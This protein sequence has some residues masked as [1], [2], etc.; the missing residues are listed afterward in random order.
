MQSP[1]EKASGRGSWQ[2]SLVNPR[3]GSQE[4]L[5]CAKGQEVTVGRGPE[6]HWQLGS[7]DLSRVHARFYW[8]GDALVVEDLDSK[9][10]TGVNG[11]RIPPSR[12]THLSDGDRV[13][14][15]SEFVDVALASRQGATTAYRPIA[16]I[17]LARLPAKQAAPEPVV[18]KAGPAPRTLE[19]VGPSDL[20]RLPSIKATP[21]AP[22]AN[23]HAN[24]QA[25]NL[26]LRHAGAAVPPPKLT[27]VDQDDA[28]TLCD[29]PT[30]PGRGAG[31]LARAPSLSPDTERT[32]RFDT[33]PPDLGQKPARRS[34]DASL[35]PAAAASRGRLVAM[36]AACIGV[37][38]VAAA[39]FVGTRI[40]P[41]SVAPPVPF[42]DT[43]ST[44]ASVAAPAT[45]PAAGVVADD[46]TVPAAQ[47]TR[48][49]IVAY[50]AGRFADAR[51][52]YL[53][54]RQRAPDDRAVAVAIRVL[55]RK[56]EVSP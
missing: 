5:I 51:S 38:I 3:P 13:A 53:R 45:A 52:T 8:L 18:A 25:K 47:L 28:P 24:G 36:G 23:G 29:R 48:D 32:G 1:S 12:P 40:I 50:D 44:A 30:N 6:A 2:L 42:T 35:R 11:Y 54:L 22:H 43:R 55:E 34:P 33:L 4:R 20:Q 9:N 16:A 15:G 31:D 46:P 21:A 7:S 37:G 10:G 17:P 14:L 41:A 56:M 39:L 19:D 49:A 27:A 26:S